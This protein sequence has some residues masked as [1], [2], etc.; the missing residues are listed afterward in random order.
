MLKTTEIL[1]FWC[2][3]V[4]SGA[5]RHYLVLSGAV[6]CYLVLY[7]AIWCCLAL[8]GASGAVWRYLCAIWRYLVPSGN[9]SLYFI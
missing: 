3:L 7:D 5:V 4:L 6:W 1:T 2:Y 9:I 8:S